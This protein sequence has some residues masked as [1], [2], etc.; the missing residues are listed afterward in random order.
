MCRSLLIDPSTSSHPTPSP[1]TPH[2][3][4]LTPYPLPHP[5][6]CS[7]P[8]PELWPRQTKCTPPPSYHLLYSIHSLYSLY[9]IHLLQTKC[10]RFHPPGDEIYRESEISIFEVDPKVTV[11]VY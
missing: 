3:N 2:L 11:V 10:T 6:L 4:P 5:T 7:S 1:L 8:R 9:S